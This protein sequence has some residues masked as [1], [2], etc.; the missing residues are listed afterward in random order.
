MWP[1]RLSE[2]SYNAALPLKNNSQSLSHP[3]LHSK[4]ILGQLL[5]LDAIR[6][7]AQLTVMVTDDTQYKQLVDLRGPPAL[8][9]LNLLQAVCDTLLSFNIPLTCTY[10]NS[11]WTRP[12]T[13]H[14]NVG[15]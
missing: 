14:S 6:L 7:C 1:A 13:R 9:L 10:P 8:A 11:A 2:S 3:G 5:G 15:M 12:S 4:T